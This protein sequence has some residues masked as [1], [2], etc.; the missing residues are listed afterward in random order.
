M[1]QYFQGLV[2]I[3]LP[4]TTPP[5]PEKELLMLIS[6]NNVTVDPNVQTGSENK[7]VKK[8]FLTHK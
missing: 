6:N 4:N 1:D 2:G 7:I 8:M 3:M 5:P